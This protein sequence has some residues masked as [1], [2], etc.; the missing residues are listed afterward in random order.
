M[1]GLASLVMR[2]RVQ[3]VLV[4][5][6]FAMLALLVPPVSILSA[7]VVALVTLREGTKSGLTVAGLAALACGALA[8]VLF[9][10]PVPVLGFVLVLWV[11]VWGLALFLRTSR[12]LDLTVVAAMLTGL[13]IAMAYSLQITAAEWQELLAPLGEGLQQSGMLDAAQ[14]DTFTAALAQWM[15]GLLAAAF[16]AQMVLA[17]LIARW[18]Q[19]KLYNPGGFGAE[20]HELRLHR[21]VAFLALPLLAVLVLGIEGGWPLVRYLGPLLTVGYFFQGLAVA[22]GVVAKSKLHRGWLYGLYA[23]LLLAMGYTVLVLATVGYTD[24]WLDYR[25]RVSRTGPSSS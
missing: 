22:H 9:P 11:P 12:S 24:A 18:W 21:A 6:G 17:L 3:A 4:A 1:G 8:F 20:F 14:G 25:A 13:L 2:G 23:L 7:A 15:P 10:D 19:A 16:F 5:A